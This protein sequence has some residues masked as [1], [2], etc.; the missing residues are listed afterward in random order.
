MPV[1]KAK[2]IAFWDSALDVWTPIGEPDTLPTFERL[3]AYSATFPNSGMTSNG[4]AYEHPTWEPRTHGSGSSY[5]PTDE[6]SLLPTP[7]VQDGKNTGGPSQFERNTPPLNTRVLMLPTPTVSDTNGPGTHGDGGLDLRTAVNLLP[8]PRASDG[9]K[10]GPNQRGSKG[11][12]MLPSAVTHLLLPTPN[13]TLGRPNAGGSHPDRRKATGHQVNLDD[14]AEHLLLPTPVAQPG[15]GGPENHLRKKPGRQ[16]VT[17][18][19]IIVENDLLETNGK[20]HGE[21]TPPPSTAGSE[22]S[23]AELP[24]QLS[25]LDAMEEQD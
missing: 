6:T 23:A 17:D 19:A 13:A 18:L 15:G 21:T 1:P 7:T 20:L 3:A 2:P 16:V 14:I 4:V 22:P 8:S 11:D 25:L 9:E 12:R 5:S 24:G 10:G